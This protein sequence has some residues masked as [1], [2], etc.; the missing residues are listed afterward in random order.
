MASTTVQ[1]TPEQIEAML[2]VARKWDRRSH[3][4]QTAELVAQLLA[5]KA[6]A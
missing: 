2:R 4:A 5:M 3:T 1:A 6:T